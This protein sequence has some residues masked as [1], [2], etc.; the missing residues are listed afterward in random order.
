ML[1]GIILGPGD[2]RRVA[3]NDTPFPE[4]TT[5]ESVDIEKLRQVYLAELDRLR[6]KLFNGELDG[7]EA[8]FIHA[9]MGVLMML[10]GELPGEL[11]IE[12]VSAAPTITNSAGGSPDAAITG[13]DATTIPTT[14]DDWK[15]MIGR[16]P[17]VF[18]R[19]VRRW[20]VASRRAIAEKIN[21]GEVAPKVLGW[22]QQTILPTAGFLGTL[23]SNQSTWPS[24]RRGLVHDIMT[25]LRNF[26]AAGIYLEDGKLA[27]VRAMYNSA[28]SHLRETIAAIQFEL[29]TVR[30]SIDGLHGV[31]LAPDISHGHFNSILR[32]LFEN[33][34]QHP[35]TEPLKINIIHRGRTLTISDNGAGMSPEALAAIRKGTPIH[36]GLAVDPNGPDQ[37]HGLGWSESIRES[38]KRLE[39]Q[40][41]ID[42][43]EGKGT[44]VT[45]TLPPGSLDLDEQFTLPFIGLP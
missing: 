17:V 7:W 27:H 22:L 15:N 37:G 20:D 19:A 1:L 11:R 6:R 43:E 35:G 13:P 28:P 31:H 4:E 16:D 24:D 10:L 9:R 32:N 25:R 29:E 26:S 3:V 42:S 23:M 38:C 41:T 18:L 8:S 2:T 40:W 39:I 12:K 30:F 14:D 5:P 21:A 33:A 44:T 34:A 45:L 36:N